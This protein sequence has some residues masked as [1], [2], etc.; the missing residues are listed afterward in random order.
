MK[1]SNAVIS[2]ATFLVCVAVSLPVFAEDA[3]SADKALELLQE[4]NM[5]FVKM[6]L[7][8]SNV[9]IEQRE[10]TAINGQKP[11]AIVFACSDSRVPVE[12]I[13]DRGIG[14]I[15]VVRVAGNIIMDSSV[16]GS[17]EFAA[18]RLHPPLL[19][20][21][22]H[23][24]CG[25][26]KAAIAGVHEKG[27]M[28][29]IQS[30]IEQAATLVKKEHPDLRGSELMNAVIKGIVFQAKSD[31]LSQSRLIKEMSESGKLKIVAGV[32]D[33]KTGETEWVR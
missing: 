13:F 16:I 17:I 20:I 28:G 21:L 27:S 11:F 9:S 3:I 15:F 6:K 19:V 22:G 30:K 7:R 31:I 24:E 32:Y 26:V 29:D 23:T 25:A 5:R 12:I 2:I 33:V 18:V 8:H 4:G 1:K 10:N 14:D